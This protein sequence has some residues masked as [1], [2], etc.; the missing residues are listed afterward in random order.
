MKATDNDDGGGRHVLPGRN[1]KRRRRAAGLALS[2]LAGVSSGLPAATYD[3]EHNF[4]L[5]PGGNVVP[6][7]TAT[8]YAHSYIRERRDDCEDF[9]VEPAQGAAFN[10][11][12]R[13]ILKDRRGRVRNKGVDGRYRDVTNG[14]TPVPAAGLSESVRAFTAGCRS[15]ADAHC[16]I[17]VDSFGA[18]DRVTGTIRAWGEATAALRPP[19]RSKAYAFSM[20]LVEAQGGRMMRNGNIRWRRT[21]RDLVAGR[22]NSRRQVDPIDF[23]VHDLVTGEEHTG[24]L[25]SVVI[26]VRK[27]GGGGFTWAEDVVEVSAHDLDFKIEFPSKLTSLQGGLDLQVRGGRVTVSNATGHYA[28]VL[29]PVG[30]RVPFD[31][32]LED[33]EEF[34]YDL[35]DFDGHDLE[36][37]LEFSGAGE[38]EEERA[39]DPELTVVPASTPS[40]A[41]ALTLSWPPQNCPVVV[42]QCTNLRNWAD[43]PLTEPVLRNGMHTLTVPVDPER[44]AFFRLRTEEAEVIDRDGPKCEAQGF[45]GEPMILVQFS[46]PVDPRS[47]RDP[48][49][50]LVLR[51]GGEVLPPPEVQL[52]APDAAVLFLAEPLQPGV[53]YRLLLPGGITD[54]AGNP[55]RPEYLLPVECDTGPGRPPGEGLPPRLDPRVP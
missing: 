3:V 2:F 25:Y 8:Y 45:C 1:V 39:A 37:N 35:G 54:L 55:M 27:A 40:R 18:G 13:D 9:A 42:Q 30:T 47:A 26:D 53:P 22:A 24:R 21:V 15:W 49:H 16:E 36:V 46:E 7:V 4:R 44:S 51:E 6:R 14:A 28:G 48:F 29:P 43:L 41:P 33:E 38:A 19:R 5:R 34:D 52:L 32:P 10:P 17:E 23:T 11:Y 12:G 50:Y 31:F 20:T